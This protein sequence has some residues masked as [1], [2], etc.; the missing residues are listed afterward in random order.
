MPTP[1]RF[2][3]RD[4]AVALAINLVWGLNI[5]AV[6]LSVNLVPPFTAA[7]LRQS[8][9]LVV[10][11]PW[12]RIVPGRMR[13]LLALSM[14]IGGG[15]F[16]IVNLSLVVTKNVGALAIAGQ[17]GAPFS[18]I[19][20]IIFL[21]ERIGPIRIAGMALAMGGCGLLVF[22]PSAAK[23]IPGL[24]LT[25]VASLLWAIGSLLQR[26]LVGVGIPTMYAWVGLGGTIVLAPLALAFEAPVMTG[27]VAIPPIA[28]L[29]IAF[30]A[31][32]STLI[33]SGGMA[34][35]L[36]RHPVTTVI[37]VTLG[38]PV[39]GVLAS[40]IV[41]GNPLTPVMVLGGI[42]ALSGVAIVTM[43][44]ASAKEAERGEES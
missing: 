40:S 28:F 18:L 41:F 36:Q 6:K 42:V 13:D 25:V 4:F 29:W 43:R 9:V 1:A 37:P 39:I 2:G 31:L 12:L 23:E 3:P 19:L 17:L 16:A 24:L 15:F 10:C 5:I 7:L 21:G 34:W 26:Q 11:L 33:G 14:V 32:G 30:S 27:A 44:T 35:L 8:L 20:A 38:A 22:D